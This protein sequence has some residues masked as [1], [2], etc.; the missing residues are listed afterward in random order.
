MGRTEAEG[1]GDVVPAEAA[2]LPTGIDNTLTHS[3]D[4]LTTPPNIRVE[5][6]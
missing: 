6:R 1:F 4:P 3:A 2:V 5:E